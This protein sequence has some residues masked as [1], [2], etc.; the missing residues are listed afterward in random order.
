MEL[1]QPANSDARVADVD[2][3][4]TGANET[5]NSPIINPYVRNLVDQTTANDAA[6]DEAFDSF[7]AYSRTPVA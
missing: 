6:V 4:S 7:V 5:L 2:Q 3:D 1:N